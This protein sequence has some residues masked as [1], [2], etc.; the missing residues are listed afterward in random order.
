MEKKN[1]KDKSQGNRVFNSKIKTNLWRIMI[2]K[3]KQKHNNNDNY[4]KKL[5]QSI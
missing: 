4:R 1:K 5:K 3:Q 2:W